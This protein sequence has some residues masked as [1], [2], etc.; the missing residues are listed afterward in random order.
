[1]KDAQRILI[2]GVDSFVGKSIFEWL[3]QWGDIYAVDFIDLKCEEWK[4]RDFSP[5]DVIIHIA[6]I[7]HMSFDPKL[8][9]YYFKINRDLTIEVAKKSKAEGVKQFIFISTMSVYGDNNNSLKLRVINLNTIPQPTNFYGESKLQAENGIVCLSSESFK[10]AIIRPPMIYGKNAKGNYPVLAKFAKILPIFPNIQNQRSM[11]HIDNF[12]E[13]IRLL[14]NNNE[15]GLFF[16]QNNEYVKTTEMIRFI[17]AFHGK[18]VILT[19][20]FNPLLRLLSR[21]IQFINKAFGSLVYDKAISVYKE[22]YCVRDF[23]QSIVATEG[24]LAEN[25]TSFFD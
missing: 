3:K 15:E 6:G 10:V 25:T 9:D 2:T 13:F 11:I 4:E 17:S 7:V 8:K 12:C 22:E 23:Y 24:T 1:M 18:K 19:K 21:R 5:Y 20:V 16:P 14:I